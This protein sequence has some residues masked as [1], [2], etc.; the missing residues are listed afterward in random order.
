MVLRLRRSARLVDRVY[1]RHWRPI[2]L[3]A[4]HECDGRDVAVVLRRRPF[5]AAPVV[6]TMTRALATTVVSAA[7][8]LMTVLRPAAA[9]A[10][11]VTA[12]TL[13]GAV[14]ALVLSRA[15]RGPVRGLAGRGD[16]S[17]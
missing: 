3:L 7:A 12:A 16:R 6:I 9:L 17:L 2:V 15:L 11:A 10:T 4:L 1:G 13:V 5:V 8:T 14:M